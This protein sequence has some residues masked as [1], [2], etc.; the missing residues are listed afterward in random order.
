M[1]HRRCA[2]Q[3]QPGDH[4]QDRG[5]G[6][7]ADE[8]EEQIAAD[9]RDEMDRGHVAAAFQAAVGHQEAGSVA[10]MVIAPKPMMKV[11]R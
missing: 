7:R 10:T 11:S 2:R 1:R 6:D 3:G 9:R 4:R 5:E 8:A